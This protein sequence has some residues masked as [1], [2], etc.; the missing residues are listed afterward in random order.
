MLSFYA[1]VLNDHAQIFVASLLV[2][3]TA[4]VF[5]SQCIVIP[6]VGPAPENELATWQQ[7]AVNWINQ[8]PGVLP[9]LGEVYQLSFNFRSKTFAGQSKTGAWLILL[10][11]CLERIKSVPWVVGGLPLADPVT[12]ADLVYTIPPVVAVV[13]SLLYPEVKQDIEDEH[14]D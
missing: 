13:Q 14:I 4:Q 8:V 9:S 11:F 2:D 10:V 6:R 12:L 7:R 3:V 1:I 5:L